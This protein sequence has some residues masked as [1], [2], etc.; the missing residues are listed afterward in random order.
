MYVC[1]CDDI[2]IY[3]YIDRYKVNKI[4]FIVNR[5]GNLDFRSTTTS[6]LYP[7]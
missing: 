1:V 4:Y 2:Y 7:L 3:I 5:S 6:V